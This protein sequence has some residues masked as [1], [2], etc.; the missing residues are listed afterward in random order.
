MAIDVDG[1]IGEVYEWNGSDWNVIG[2][3]WEWDGSQ[4]VPVYS[5]WSDSGITKSGNQ[6]L[7]KKVWTTV[8]G[9][10]VRSGYPRTVIT[11]NGIQVPAGTY[12]ITG[13]LRWLQPYGG[14]ARGVRVVHNG[15]AVPGLELPSTNLQTVPVDETV[16]LTDGLIQI[17]G[18]PGIDVLDLNVV[19]GTDTWLTIEAS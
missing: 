15:T 1:P 6:S 14:Q 5:S 17:Q 7:P 11:N 13:Q 4:W 8:T 2:D 18:Y 9:W 3:G 12:K 16:T 10:A 19:A